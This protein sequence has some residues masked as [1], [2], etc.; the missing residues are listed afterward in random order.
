M[1]NTNFRETYNGPNGIDDTINLVGISGYIPGGADIVEIERSLVEQDSQQSIADSSDR[2]LL[3]EWNR[4]IQTIE[5]NVGFSLRNSAED[6]GGDDE[7]SSNY[8]ASIAGDYAQNRPYA[9]SQ[10][11]G[12]YAQSQSQYDG[13]SRPAY[14]HSGQSYGQYASDLDTGRVRF[15]DNGQDRAQFRDP[16]MIAL[17]NEQRRQQELHRALSEMNT[18]PMM[19]GEKLSFDIE[20][21]NDKKNMILEQIN[22]LRMNLEDDG[23]KIGDIQLVTTDN[24]FDEVESVYKQLRY[25]NDHQRY[26]GFANEFAQMGALGLEFF[27]DGKK[28]YFGMSPDLTG[29][30]TTLGIK[31]RRLSYET[32]SLVSDG[33]REY[34][35]GNFSRVCLEL[36]P[37]LFLHARMQANKSGKSETRPSNNEVSSAM[38]NLR[39][40][41]DRS[42]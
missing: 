25:R 10:Y 4:K 6:P 31:M 32:S 39:N 38:S 21:S 2:D 13:D 14:T 24:T 8:D 41:S 40:I 16:G 17:S 1:A 12:Q 20:K 34:N 33:M 15:Q 37:S 23:V 27:F 36:I 11:G 7:I 28:K 22:M 35:V 42:R 30:S 19:N 26:C 9:Q 5:S 18:H 29:W 3:S